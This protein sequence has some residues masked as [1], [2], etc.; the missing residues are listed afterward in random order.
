MKRS[1]SESL[2]P[3]VAEADDVAPP[4]PSPETE[5]ENLALKRYQELCSAWGEGRFNMPETVDATIAD[6]VAPDVVWDLETA[7]GHSGL[8]AFKTYEYDTVSDWFEFLA[9]FDLADI[10]MSAVPSSLNPS[11]IWQRVRCLATAKATGKS[12]VLDAIFIITFEGEKV[13]HFTGIYAD[14]DRVAALFKPGD[15]ASAQVTPPSFEPLA[16]PMPAFEKIFAAWGTGAFSAA[17]TKQAA[18]ETLARADGLLDCTC[19]L[20]PELFKLYQ[21]HDG[22]DQYINGVVGEWEFERLD[23]TVEAGLRPGCVL[24][25]LSADVKHQ[26]TGKTAKGI[27]IFSENG[28]DADG[29]WAY[30]KLFWANPAV[31]MSLY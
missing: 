23:S 2:T 11:E 29:K 18:L 4:K 6:Y 14:P 20:R 26:R 7:N 3:N 31:A 15:D 13:K 12:M 17:D 16:D 8:P 21:G 25:K 30:G 27:V 28:Y 24:Q 19:S 9:K 5:T 1:D 22:I 10:E